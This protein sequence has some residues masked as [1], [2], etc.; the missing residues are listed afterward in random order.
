[1]WVQCVCVCGVCVCV[2]EHAAC[3]YCVCPACL[4]ARLRVCGVGVEVW[5]GGERKS[6]CDDLVTRV[7]EVL[8]DQKFDIQAAQLDLTSLALILQDSPAQHL[9][10]HNI[11]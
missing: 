9:R 6:I 8:Q 4:R 1:M 2:C 5:E 10:A 11:P 7:A 3:V